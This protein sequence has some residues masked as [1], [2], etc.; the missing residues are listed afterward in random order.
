[1]GTTLTAADCVVPFV[2]G[3]FLYIAT[4]GVVPGLV[5]D[6]KTLKQGGGTQLLKELLAMAVGM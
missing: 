2:A 3:G 6:S 5:E 4:V 1:M